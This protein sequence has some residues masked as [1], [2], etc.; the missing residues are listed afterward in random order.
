[1]DS[2]DFSAQGYKITVC[3]DETGKVISVNYITPYFDDGAI[4]KILENNAP[5]VTWSKGS[6]Q[7]NF[8]DPSKP[9]FWSADGYF[10]VLTHMTFFGTPVMKLQVSTEKVKTLIEQKRKPADL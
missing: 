4:D 9:A 6:N 3:L 10:A 5:S 8:A 1:L 7:G 2:Y